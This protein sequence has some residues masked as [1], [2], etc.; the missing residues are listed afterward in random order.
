MPMPLFLSFCLL[1]CLSPGRWAHAQPVHLDAQGRPNV[2]FISIDDLN[3]DLG[4]Y[5]DPSFKTPNIDRLATRGVLFSR[6]Y[7]QFPLCNPSRA[8]LLTGLRPDR[9]G[10]YDLETHFRRRHPDL[11]TLPQRFRRAGYR[12]ARVGKVFH[13]GVPGGI[14][15]DGL[16]DTL[17]W[18]VRV[19][20]KGRDR[21]EQNRL[22]RL[23]PDAVGLGANHAVLRAVGEDGEQTDG[24]VA[25]EALRLIADSRDRPFFIAAGFYRPHL[26]FVAP[27]RWFDQHPAEGVRLPERPAGDLDDIPDAAFFTW[28]PDWGLSEDAIRKSIQG[29]RASVSFVDAQVGRLLDGLDSLGLVDRTIVVLWS[30]HGFNLGEHGQWQKRSLF[31]KSLRVPLIIAAPGVRKGSECGRTVELTDLYPT[32]LDLAGLPVP[33]S[34]SGR[35]LRPLMHRP[36]A[37]WGRPAFSQLSLSDS[38]AWRIARTLPGFDPTRTRLKVHPHGTMGRSVRTERWRYTEWDHGR[39]GVE[40]YDESRDPG[41]FRNLADSPRHRRVRRRLSGVL[42]SNF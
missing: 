16:D 14:G 15:T 1:A 6:A 36:R 35:S 21:Q 25:S 34:L 22:I 3:T 41:E 12:V 31:E 11:V 4:A 27:R 33:D 5:G 26:P 42:R 24:M 28:P 23:L 40:L 2:L 13:Y 8:S 10:V 17:S 7:T 18:D 37:A 19:N 32:L 9:I 39:L 30:D 38:A 20:P 29:Y